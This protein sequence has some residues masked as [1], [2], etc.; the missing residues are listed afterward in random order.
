MTKFFSWLTNPPTDGSRSILQGKL[1]FTFNLPELENSAYK[2]SGGKL[3][4]FD[5]DPGAELLFTHG[6]HRLSVFI[7]RNAGSVLGGTLTVRGF[8]VESWSAGGLRWVIVS[9]AAPSDVHA[10][11]ELL[12]RAQSGN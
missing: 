12:E 9:D 5:H 4:Y 3:I 2:L 8:G 7:T 1:P 10:L 11:A 6:Q